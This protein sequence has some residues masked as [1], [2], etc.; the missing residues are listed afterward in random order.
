MLQL[1]F[2]AS[3]R[4]P[5]RSLQVL[6]AVWW[7]LFALQLG[8]QPVA[9]AGVT[10]L[11]E[12]GEPQVLTS[13]LSAW[14]DDKGS[15][16]VD[17]VHAL[18]ETAFKPLPRRQDAPQGPRQALWV[19]LD[20]HA[21]T[22]PSTW[23]LST[24][25]VS[26]DQVD[27]YYRDA[28]ENGWL[29]QRAGTSVPV[30]Q[31]P[32]SEKRPTFELLHKTT[33]NQRLYIRVHDKYG[34]WTGLQAMTVKTYTERNQREMLLWG[35]YVGVA[36]VV[37]CLGIANWFSSRET[38][39]LS[40][41]AYNSLMTLAQLS[42]IGLSGTLFFS[43][44]PWLNEFGVFAFLCIA[45]TAFL[46]FS[47]QSSQ[48]M[49]YAR[50]LA[51]V[52]VVYVALSALIVL[53]FALV[54]TSFYP[55]YTAPLYVESIT[56]RADFFSVVIIFL[57]FGCGVLISVMFFVTWRRGHGFSGMALVVI[58]I[59]LVSSVPQILYSL[60]A[61]PR[62]WLSEHGLL[63]GLMFESVAMLYVMQR[64]S[65]SLAHNEG[66]LRHLKLHDALTG[67]M[68]RSSAIER[69]DTLLARA[70]Q[71]QKICD[72]LYLHVDYIDEIARLHGHEVS[73]AALLL[74]ARN[75][76][77]L[78]NSGDLVTRLD[79][80]SFML[81]LDNKAVQER[82]VETLRAMATT[83][84]AKGLNEQPFLNSVVKLEIRIWI[85]RIHGEHA[86]AAKVVER[87]EKRAAETA[88]S[89]SGKR[90]YFLPHPSHGASKL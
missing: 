43:H 27:L 51:W 33:G 55:L 42:I 49:R 78:R 39:W 44:L 58:V 84:I 11:R 14:V 17:E 67:L 76:T 4:T 41:A 3:I 22:A 19:R 20:V 29:V 81:A 38:V 79:H 7:C 36:I 34:S 47:I 60:N 61:I 65:R 75:I 45:S 59:T 25:Q 57:T 26:I 6:W 54:P 9:T 52:A 21:E 74:T 70:Q 16:T 73:E 5:R 82:S 48:A 13:A 24:P 66:R 86:T 80:S 83:L 35:L 85:A 90:I 56:Q 18:P 62:S 15:A 68:P 89:A 88:P 23:I 1:N 63:L 28:T 31:W 50:K 32:I 87:L 46:L 72:V 71:H 64:H 40:Y 8:A 69:L 12:T 30:A 2:L 37:L 53:A 77:E 10:A